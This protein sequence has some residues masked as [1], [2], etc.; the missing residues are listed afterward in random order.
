M[1]ASGS[2]F[3]FGVDKERAQIEKIFTNLSAGEV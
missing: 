2:R 3:Y 1:V